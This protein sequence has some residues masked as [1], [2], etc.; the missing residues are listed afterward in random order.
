MEDLTLTDLDILIESLTTWEADASALVGDLI[1]HMVASKEMRETDEFKQQA[2]TRESSSALKKATRAEAS[3]MLKAK[4][5]GIKNHLI[6]E[7]LL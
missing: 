6:A 2:A 4:L 3:I 1:V 7:A 5:M